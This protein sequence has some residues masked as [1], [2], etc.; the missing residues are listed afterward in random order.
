MRDIGD[1]LQFQHPSAPFQG[2]RGAKHLT[3]PGISMFP[4]GEQKGPSLSVCK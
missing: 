4:S 1:T 3:D 2:M